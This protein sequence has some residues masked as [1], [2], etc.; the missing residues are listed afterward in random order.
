MMRKWYLTQIVK[1]N[2]T[3]LIK[4]NQSICKFKTI[5]KIG[6]VACEADWNQQIIFDCICGCVD[7]RAMF[8]QPPLNSFSAP[9]VLG[10]VSNAEPHQLVMEMSECAAASPKAINLSTLTLYKYAHDVRQ[11]STIPTRPTCVL[12]DT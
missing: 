3:K 1:H 2:L 8:T 5:N 4:N 7:K 9:G 12:R 6:M 11:A 10:A